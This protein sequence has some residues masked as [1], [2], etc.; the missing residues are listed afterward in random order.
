MMIHIHFSAQCVPIEKIEDLVKTPNGWKSAVLMLDAIKNNY[1]DKTTEELAWIK[2]VSNLI[3]T[4]M[5]ENFRTGTHL[6]AEGAGF[7]GEDIYVHNGN[8]TQTIHCRHKKCGKYKVL[9]WNKLYC[10]NCDI[11]L[12]RDDIAE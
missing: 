10:A 6:I 12:T 8:I 2:D 9:N 11:D 5:P 3:S 7:Y 1:Y 4:T